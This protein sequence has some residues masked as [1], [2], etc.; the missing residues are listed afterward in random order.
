[1]LL[2]FGSFFSKAIVDGTSTF[3]V[4]FG[5]RNSNAKCIYEFEYTLYSVL[6]VVVHSELR[7]R[8]GV[9]LLY[10]LILIANT[11]RNRFY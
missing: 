7:R 5:E 6:A 9:F 2:L 3:C 1:M 10:L 4:F 11:Q 8:P